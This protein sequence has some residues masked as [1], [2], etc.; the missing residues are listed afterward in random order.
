M[1]Q[2]AAHQHGW[3]YEAEISNAESLR[4]SCDC[5]A[6]GWRKAIFRGGERV[7]SEIVA[8][9]P[10][11]TFDRLTRTLA[12]AQVTARPTRPQERAAVAKASAWHGDDW[13]SRERGD[14]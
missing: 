2:P 6:L 3:T 8:Y 4:Y 11:E 12:A 9:R 10:G 1:T 5:G 13:R 7:G 14:R